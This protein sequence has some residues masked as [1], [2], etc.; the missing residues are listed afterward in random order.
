MKAAEISKLEVGLQQLQLDL[1]ETMKN[2]LIKYLQLL[3]KWNQTY[4]LTAVHP[5]DRL[6]KHIFDSLVI[7]PYLQGD[8]IVDV[9]TGA[10]LP[11]VVLAIARPD[12]QFILI[13]SNAKKVRFVKQV[14]MDLSLS[15]VT[16]ICT[17]VEQWK[18]HDSFTSVISRAY[19]RLAQFYSQTALLATS[20][21]HWL[22]MKGAITTDE[23]AEV[24]N[25]SIEII[26]LQ[27]PQLE[28]VRT[29]CIMTQFK[30]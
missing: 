23:L 22:A 10:G 4:N 11:G 8:K 6:I 2:Q 18:V 9:G 24:A 5:D 3:D 29:L 1:S 13:D 20:D 25:L 28:A 27:V 21:T 12:L 15:H 26:P 7:L 17:R 19:S 14:I 30:R 16:A